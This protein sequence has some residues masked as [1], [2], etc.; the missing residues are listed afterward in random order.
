MAQPGQGTTSPEPTKSKRDSMTAASTGSLAKSAPQLSPQRRD[1]FNS[2]S[3][4]TSMPHRQ[5]FAE[6]LRGMPHSPRSR[7]PSF[8]QQAL[9]ELLNNP[10]APKSNDSRFAGRDWR[11]IQLGEVIDQNEVRFVE[12]DTSVEDAANVRS[13]S[14]YCRIIQ[15]LTTS[16]CS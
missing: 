3:P 14:V 7:H 11:T 15:V 10:P 1:S 8:S 12:A 9:Q 2:K 13:C 4:N 16:S 6:N 5:S